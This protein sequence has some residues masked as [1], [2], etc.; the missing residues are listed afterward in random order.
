M[1]RPNPIYVALVLAATAA[2][3]A[4]PSESRIA[5]RGG[6][7]ILKVPDFQ[8][9][10]AAALNLADKYGA[11]LREAETQ[12]NLSGQKHGDLLFQLDSGKLGAMVGDLRDIGK[13]YSE[14]L[15]TTDQTSYYNKLGKRIAILRQNEIELLNLL[16]GSRQMKGPDVLYLQFR[17]FQSRVEASDAT[18]DALD[19]ERAARRAEL[20]VSLFEPEPRQ[21][22]D[23]RNWRAHAAYRGK[24]AFFLV[25]RK[26]VTLAYLV[27]WTAPFWIP[28]AV[29]L[30]FLWLWGRRRIRAWRA[31]PAGA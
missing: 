11:E 24:G 21:A 27:L 29:I 7:I 6:S 1:K 16:R 17:L 25:T 9:A 4:Q 19:L 10:R 14:R 15:Q 12:V 3:A 23:W 13:L 26:L 20:R 30:Y 22:L 5:I 31:R 8:T 18:Q 2:A 28:G